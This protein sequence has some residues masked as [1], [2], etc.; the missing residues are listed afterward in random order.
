MC[1]KDIIASKVA[2]KT[3]QKDVVFINRALKRY[4]DLV[5]MLKILEDD[6]ETGFKK[7]AKVEFK[8]KLADGNLN[9]EQYCRERN[10]N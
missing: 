2:L 5:G 7:L 3:L 9:Y 1:I 10:I 4:S 8:R 6:K